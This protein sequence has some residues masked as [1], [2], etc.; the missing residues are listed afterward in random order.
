MNSFEKLLNY[1]PHYLSNS[2]KDLLFKEALVDNFK[3]HYKNCEPYKRLCIKRGWELPVKKNFDLKDFPYLPAEIFKNMHL[4]SIPNPNIIKTLHSSATSSQT[5]STIFLDKETS[6]RQMQTLVWFLS[7]RLGKNR[8][9]FIVMDV[10]PK[11]IGYGKSTISARAAAVRGFLTASSSYTYCMNQD[12]AGEL[13]VELDKL[14]KSLNEAQK[15][16]DKAI[17]FGFTYVLY[18]YAAKQLQK[19]KVKFKLPNLTILHIGGWKK[20]QSQAT[21]K[22]TFNKTMAN[23]FGVKL[24]N[25]IDCYGFTEQLGIVYLDGKDGLKRTSEVSEIIVRNQNTLLPCK[26]GEEGLLEFITPLPLSYPGNAILT[27]DIGRVVTREKGKD[28]RQGVAFEI[29]GRRKKAEIRG[30]G[31]ILS[32]SM[33]NNKKK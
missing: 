27:D 6:K 18:I 3:H 13:H 23:V 2:D 22:K 8:R 14:E 21:D 30:C 26:D 19:K 31:D 20:L 17:I 24:E 16:G 10:D 7:H 9:P 28:G 4:S 32:E 15:S 12:K 25:I 5:P 11:D 29:L 33:F 1:E